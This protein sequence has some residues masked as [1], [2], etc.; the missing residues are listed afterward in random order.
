VRP[1]YRIALWVAAIGI[2][3]TV[4]IG[5][6]FGGVVLRQTTV[7]KPAAADAAAEFARVHERFK[8][9]VHGPGIITDFTPPGGGRMLVWVE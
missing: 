8:G 4:A 7:S 5:A 1:V 6:L 2:A 9:R 3:L